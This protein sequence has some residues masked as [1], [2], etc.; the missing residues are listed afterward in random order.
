MKRILLLLCCVLLL[1]TGCAPPAESPID[2]GRIDMNNQKI[3]IIGNSHSVDAFHL[4][5]EACAD[6]YP[7]TDLTLGVLYYSGCSISKH[8]SF[9][10]SGE[11]VYDYYK[12]TNGRWKIDK[13]V[14]MVSVL[15]D[16]DWSIIM[17]QAAKTDLDNTLNKRG[18]RALEKIVNQNVSAPHT[19]MWHTSWPSPNDEFFFSDEAPK[20]APE[21]YKEN[22]TKLYDFDPVKQYIVLINMAKRHILRDETYALGICTGAGIMH[23]YRAEGCDQRELWRDY[24]HLN[25]LGRLVAAYSMLTQ[26]TG[27]PIERIGIDTLPKELRHHMFREEGDLTLTQEMKDVI[28]RSANYALTAPFTLPQEN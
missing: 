2:S 9:A 18:R 27:R 25:D 20:A 17:L 24:T 22:L 23:A 12:N 11:K 14:D 19:F 3:L 21:G 10:Q 15:Q 16:Q 5:Y 28:I 8:V 13:D 6:Q 1:L 4:L 26:L 7:D